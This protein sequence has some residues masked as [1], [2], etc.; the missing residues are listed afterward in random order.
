MGELSDSLCQTIEAKIGAKTYKLHRMTM[1]M[2]AALEQEAEKATPME[3]LKVMSMEDRAQL[4][5]AYLQTTAGRLSMLAMSITKAGTKITSEQLGDSLGVRD[6]VSVIE[7]VTLL[8]ND[9]A[10]ESI[11]GEDDGAGN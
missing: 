1:G 2:Y 3:L 8:L 6:M 10:G 5:I 7:S 9:L 11:P 4:P